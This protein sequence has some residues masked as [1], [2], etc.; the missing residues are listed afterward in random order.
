MADK[1]EVTKL[2][3]WL[4]VSSLVAA[5]LVLPA[6]Y[7]QTASENL[8]S[9]G[10]LLSVVVWLYF[11]V[12]VAILLRLANDNVAWIK[13]HITELL[14]VFI[15]CPLFLFLVED[16]NLF[17]LAPILAITRIF[18]LAKFIKA[19]KLAKLLKSD[20]IVR[21]APSVAGVLEVVIGVIVLILTLGILGLI[22][23]DE[24]HNF[25]EGLRFWFDGLKNIANI[26]WPALLVSALILLGLF[27]Q[28]SKSASDALNKTKR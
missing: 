23:S 2:E 20:K 27:Y 21:E 13:S 9:L 18:R 6:V 11:A 17:A 28:I 4:D 1:S 14:I 12:E 15:S 16:Q 19:V 25:G 26:P 22:V 24:A 7:F 10:E 5:L 8:A 3:G